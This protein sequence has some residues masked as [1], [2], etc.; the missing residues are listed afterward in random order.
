[1]FVSCFIV[2]APLDSALLTSSMSLA[3]SSVPHTTFSLFFIFNLCVCV[4]CVPCLL[5]EGNSPGVKDIHFSAKGWR[6]VGTMALFYP[7]S[8][9]FFLFSFFPH[10][11]RAEAQKSFWNMKLLWF[12]DLPNKGVS[13]AHKA[14]AAWPGLMEQMSCLSIWR[15]SFLCITK[16]LPSHHKL[17]SLTHS[18]LPKW[19]WQEKMRSW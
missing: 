18:C 2:S 13:S 5:V 14:C 8:F 10:L 12:Q 1:M 6:L 3:L 16:S 15:S 9:F 19:W 17:C 7:A 4:L 11:W